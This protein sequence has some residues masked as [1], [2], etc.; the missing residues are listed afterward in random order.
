MT[1]ASTHAALRA[2]RRGSF[3]PV[4][5]SRRTL[6]HDASA[7]LAL[8]LYSN[9]DERVFPDAVTGRTKYGT[10]RGC[11]EDEIWFSSSTA[12]AISPRGH[13]AAAEAWQALAH[14][15]MTAEDCCESV[16]LRLTQLFGIAGTQT[17]LTGSGTEAVL[18]SLILARMLFRRRIATIIV[19]CEETG[20][21]V[22]AAAA[23]RHFLHHAAFDEV[24]PGG[25]LEGLDDIDAL[26]DTVAI[27][28]SDGALRPETE[29]DAEVAQKA[30]AALRD[31]RDLLIHSLDVSKTGQSAPS[32][33]ILA[34][35]RDAA[36]ERIAILAD[37]CQLRCS[38]PHIQAYLK[39]GF[40]VS[41]TGSKFAGGPP[42]AGAL[43]V[44][45]FILD[46]LRP[47]LLP[48]GLA[49]YSAQRD[50][51]SALRALLPLTELP[52]ANIGLALRW[53]AALAEIESFFTWP[54]HLRE[55]ILI[56]FHEEV[57]RR[58]CD[59]PD[60]DLLPPP[61]ASATTWGHTILAVAM[62]GH[63]GH[64][65]GM[66]EAAA[67]QRRLREGLGTHRF[68][69]GQ[70]VAIGT[71]GVLRVCASAVLA[72]DVAEAMSDGATL[73]DAFAPTA[74]A[75]DDLF[76]AWQSILQ[77]DGNRVHASMSV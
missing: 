21:G 1:L 65:L 48:K 20:R 34:Q 33:G 44:P 24:A 51:P 39:S 14:G 12:S 36:P 41:L 30:E 40:L 35:I 53:H 17:I 32:L 54:A 37:C 19:G 61:P 47:R 67:V 74:A 8:A 5:R 29:I 62:R 10:P 3:A 69:L 6:P 25:R 57:A 66:D 58:V 75:L 9:G 42:F 45:P 49:A 7:S 16:R 70:P 73:T 72:N 38:P 55:T 26:V 56:R 43:L 23:G 50:W 2:P 18:V 68:H 46:R 71:M 64:C 59:T 77:A 63:N 76:R 22:S 13:A 31:G 4:A 52:A 11:A 28:D 27:R 15:R 60:F